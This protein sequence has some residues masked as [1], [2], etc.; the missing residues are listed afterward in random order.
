MVVRAVADQDQDAA[1]GN[2]G[3][4]I[5]YT[6]RLS[7][8]L[9]LSFHQACD[10]GDLDVAEQLVGILEGMLIRDALGP[11][12]NRRRCIEGV[13]AAHE[14]LWHLRHPVKQYA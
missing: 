9:L 5:R 10:Q 7:D 13:V 4:S 12:E 2:P 8:K 11:L 6:R 1:V 3:A 14:R